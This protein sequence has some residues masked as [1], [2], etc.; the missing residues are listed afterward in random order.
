MLL[1]NS[2][3]NI[4]SLLT[5]FLILLF[6]VIALSQVTRKPYLQIPTPNSIIICWQTGT[7]VAGKVFY[8][9]SSQKLINNVNESENEEIYHEVK[10]TGLKPATKYFYSVESSQ[11]AEDQYFITP[12]ET[13]I[14]TPV[15][16][17]FIS[18][19]GQTDS[20]DNARRK[21]TVEEWKSFN[22]GDYHASLLISTGD[23]SEDD[24]IYQ[25]QHNY[26]SQLEPVLVTTPL[27]T[28]IGNHDD[29][30][31]VLN[32]LKTFTLPSK[33]EAGGIS[34]GT[35]KYYS[36]NYSNIHVVM[37]CTE[38]NDKEMK[39]E[40]EWL[41]KDLELNKQ[42]WLIAGM[43]QPLHSAGYHPTDGNEGAQQRRKEWLTLL[44]DHGVDLILQGHN[45]VYE[46][47][48]LVDNIIGKSTDVKDA[49]ILNSGL[50]R[51]DVGGAYK[52]PAGNKP[53]K[54]TVFIT[55]TGGGVAN[56]IKHYPVPYSFIPVKFPGSD[57]EGS[58]VIDVNKNQMD[59]KFICNELNE[60]GSH[61]WDYFTIIKDN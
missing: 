9:T 14:S 45:H 53:H 40:T 8:G 3:I 50:G 7:G 22:N 28:A 20:E 57:Y 4:K 56:A 30:D 21:Q 51:N 47:S 32:Y 15:R 60:K 55:C 10:L 26:F 34:S 18:D 59:V 54:G 37:L 43:H 19:F 38:V 16:I 6:P 12:P 23:Q 49:N 17:W 13:G 44:E 31:T 36:F 48:F 61:V 5:G 25:I 11:G 24:A 2:Q 29:H 1:K 27:Y 41:K 52:K 39:A 33:G 46:R 35:E 58:V 42:E